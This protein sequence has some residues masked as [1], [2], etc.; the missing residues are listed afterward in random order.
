M[1]RQGHGRPKT[2][3]AAQADPHHGWRSGVDA[4][5]VA[6]VAGSGAHVASGVDRVDA[7]HPV[8]QRGFDRYGVVARC[9]ARLGNGVA[10]RGQE[11]AAR[12][13]LQARA[14]SGSEREIGRAVVGEGRAGAGRRIG[15]LPVIS[16]ALTARDGRIAGCVGG[17]GAGADLD[18][19]RC[20]RLDLL[21]AETDRP[22]VV[23]HRG[24]QAGDRPD[25]NIDHAAVGH[26]NRAATDDQALLV[27]EIVD[28]AVARDGAVDGNHRRQG[29]DGQAGAGRWTAH[30]AHIAGGVN[31][32][33]R[34]CHAAAL[35]DLC[36]IVWRE[37]VR[38]SAAGDCG[39]ASQ[40]THKHL[41]LAGPGCA[42][43]NL[44]GAGGRQC[45]LVEGV[46]RIGE[47]WR[48]GRSS[49]DR[50]GST[51]L[52]P[53]IAHHVGIGGCGHVDGDAALQARRRTVLDLVGH[54][55]VGVGCGPHQAT[56]R[57][58]RHAGDVGLG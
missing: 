36:Q 27:L 18:D 32:A 20:E 40:A 11:F 19:A 44:R 9:G 41:H 37:G 33:R 6:T 8:G 1:T 26:L 24:A 42:T 25:R 23:V 39:I 30:G 48:V 28:K 21:G 56:Q 53:S 43:A 52:L 29:I 38:P 3:I 12:L 13:D 2:P 15:R 5:L 16:E 47:R 46:D 55:A 10:R 58:G 34:Q 14:R 57:L 50:Q 51:A 22:I 7:V 45:S 35:P 4:Q 54:R 17:G 31:G 49:V